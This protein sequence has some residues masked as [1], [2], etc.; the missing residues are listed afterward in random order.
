MR[1]QML[2]F[3]DGENYGS[4]IYAVLNGSVVSPFTD[5]VCLES[6]LAIDQMLLHRRWR[7]WLNVSLVSYRCSARN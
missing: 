5:N 4:A 3:T 1:F 6:R 2:T 7:H